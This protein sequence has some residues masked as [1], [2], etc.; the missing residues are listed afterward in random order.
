M[1]HPGLFPHNK[2]VNRYMPR[3]WLALEYRHRWGTP[4]FERTVTP[5]RK[6]PKPWD[7]Q[8]DR[9]DRREV[10][11]ANSAKL[12]DKRAIASLTLSA[13]GVAKGPF[14][15]NKPP[16]TY[17]PLRFN[18][19]GQQHRRWVQPTNGFARHSTTTLIKIWIKPSVPPAAS[20]DRPALTLN[21]TGSMAI[22]TWGYRC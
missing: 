7:T 5:D 19:K 11:D 16:Q 10:I 22:R 8:D 1:P 21:P 9:N 2:D 14:M 12:Q 3:Q 17:I 15:D 13:G 4:M 20:C 6:F 18:Y